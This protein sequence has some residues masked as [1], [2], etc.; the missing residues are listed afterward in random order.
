[1][2]VNVR[3]F[4]EDWTCQ[5]SPICRRPISPSMPTSPAHVSPAYG[6][7]AMDHYRLDAETIS[8][9]FFVHSYGHGG[10]GITLSWG[11][12][13]KVRNIVRSHLVGAPDTKVAVLGAGVMGLTTAR[14]KPATT[15]MTSRMKIRM[16]QL[17]PHLRR[18]ATGRS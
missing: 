3:S 10:A 6:R 4:R 2:Q 5:Q 8:N 18:S 11:C 14:K 16:Q 17:C 9:K 13:S 7:T 1:M 12:A 15:D